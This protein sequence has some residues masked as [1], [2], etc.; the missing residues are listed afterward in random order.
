MAT[1]SV[2]RRAIEFPGK[3][4]N[5]LREFNRFR[6]L[7]AEMDFGEAYGI[8]RSVGITQEPTEI[9]WLF[10]RVR[11]ARPRTVLEI[12]LQC[13]GTFF[14]WTRAAAP[15]AHLLAIDLFK[16]GVLGT[17]SAFPLALR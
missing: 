13:G 7:P 10:E 2:F 9:E 12:G 8:A 16:P 15:D 1:A 5:A 3:Y 14:L 17:W 11:E 6:S 4:R